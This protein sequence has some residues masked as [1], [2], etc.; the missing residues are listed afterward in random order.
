MPPSS[1]ASP[2]GMTTGKVSIAMDIDS[3][4]E[5]GPDGQGDRRDGFLPKKLLPPGSCQQPENSVTSY[6][7]MSWVLECLWSE[8]PLII[9]S[10]GRYKLQVLEQTCSWMA[11]LRPSGKT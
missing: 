6:R 5:A 7:S 4:H 2:V 11:S 9:E 3:R 1:F 8:H 10:L